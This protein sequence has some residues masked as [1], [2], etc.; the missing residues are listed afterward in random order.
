MKKSIEKIIIF[1]LSCNALMGCTTNNDS[2]LSN[3]TSN[4]EHKDDLIHLWSV[5]DTFKVLQDANYETY[6]DNE[7]KIVIS[8][9]KNEYENAQIIISPEKDIKSYDIT[10]SDLKDKNGN[11]FD[12]SNFKVYNQKYIEVTKTTTSRF[13]SGYYPDAL[14]PFDVAIDYKENFINKGNNQGIY[15]E[16]Y[17]PKNQNG[18]VYEGTF[19]LS[20]DNNVY[21][22]PVSVT[23]YNYTLQDTVHSRSSF[24]VHRYWNEG[25]IVSAEKNASYEMYEKYY[26]YLL[27]HRISTR[28]LPAAME[29]VDGFIIE[30]RKY[31]RDEKCSNY[32]IPYISK[33]DNELNGTCI[34]YDLY[35]TYL[36]AIATQSILDNYNYFEKASTY[37][38]MFDE[39]TSDSMIK[40][41]NKFYKKI[42]DLHFEMATLWEKDLNCEET[43]KNKIIDSMLNISQLMVTTYNK[44]FEDYVTFCP[45][46]DKYDDQDSKN[47]YMNSYTYEDNGHTITQNSEKW[48]YSAGIPKNPYASYHIDDNGYSPIVYSW[49]QYAND[50]VGNLYWSATFYL[51]RT[52]ENNKV[53]YNTLQDCYTTAM[54]FPN[55]NGDGFLLYPGAPYGIDGPVGSIRLQQILDGLE[56]YDMLYALEEKYEN[57]KLQGID[58]DFDSVLNFFYERLFTG[59]KVATS[60]ETYE[61]MREQLLSLL[62]LAQNTNVIVTKA[63]TTSSKLETTIYVPQGKEITCNGNKVKEELVENGK[64]LTI[65][66]DLINKESNFNISVDEFKATLL[67][68]AKY[69]EYKGNDLKDLFTSS[70]GTITN[71]ENGTNIEFAPSTSKR[72]LFSFASTL[73][74]MI[75]SDTNTINLILNSDSQCNIEILFTGDKSAVAIPVYSGTIKN[76]EN[77][78]DINISTLNFET[79]GNLKNVTIRLG[80]QG[81]NVSRKIA[82]KALS[83]K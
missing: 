38:A 35:K 54:R 22:I 16:C 41:A 44:K 6:Y 45:L 14:L 69:V 56:E 71:D 50:V 25:G 8:S 32:I 12:K 17:V 58:C 81:D 67:V 68:N 55:T 27:E 30:L 60:N 5:E 82:I 51:V 76:G 21:N 78:I 19:T 59:T 53:V 4:I 73:V 11:I 39:I 83:I 43:L 2:I 40:L 1:V 72:H 3:E 10:L 52:S 65:N 20:L 34:D 74:E 9:A 46:L 33:W 31:V 66:Y 36:N 48:W 24:G 42:L 61:T 49:M 77:N 63:T 64:I 79:I 62:E 28:Y 18:G 7:A 15:F 57:L 47:N 13:N 29:D 26:E 70:I 75:T 37:F 80:D 23:I